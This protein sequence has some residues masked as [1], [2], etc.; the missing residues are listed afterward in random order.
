ML[1][2]PPDEST[3]PIGRPI[4]VDCGSLGAIIDHRV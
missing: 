1:V 4:D 3:R 2:K